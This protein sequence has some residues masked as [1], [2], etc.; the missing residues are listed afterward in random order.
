MLVRIMFHLCITA[1]CQRDALH[2]FRNLPNDSVVYL[3]T[4]GLGLIML[5][6]RIFLRRGWKVRVV[7]VRKKDVL[8]VL[9]RGVLLPRLHQRAEPINGRQQ[10]NLRAAEN[11]RNFS[12]THRTG[13]G[14]LDISIHRAFHVKATSTL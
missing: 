14:V 5:S 3:T 4:A 11:K 12:C 7:C 10:A 2:C 6:A 1:N 8:R 9:L 13:L